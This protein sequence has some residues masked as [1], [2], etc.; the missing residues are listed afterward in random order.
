MSLLEDNTAYEDWLRRHCD[1]VEAD[2]KAKH[3][4]MRKNAFQF[5]RAT[6]FRWSRT[7]EALLPDLAE[8]PAVL[9][10]GDAHRGNFGTWRD[11]EGRLIWGIN[12][13]DDA[14]LMPYPL[15]LVRLC[16]SVR[17][18]EDEKVRPREAAAAILA[19]YRRGLD[20]P[21]PAFLD[22]EEAWLRPF[23]AATN[24]ERYKFWQEVEGA[25]AVPLD[26]PDKEIRHGFAK[27]FP[28]D[29]AISKIATW[30]KGGG[31]LGRPRYVAT[32]M[33]R[34][35]YIVREA[36]AL[37]P[38]SWDWAHGRKSARSHFL[39]LADGA[40]RAPD[41]FLITHKHFVFRRVS[42][43]A[44]KLDLDQGV[45]PELEALFLRAMGFELG[46][47]HA[48]DKHAA[49]IAPHLAGLPADWLH[50]AAK[51]AA[52]AVTADF[53]VWKKAMAQKAHA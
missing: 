17:L 44:R 43:D 30:I 48:A 26:Q 41:P 52:E 24:R 25:K 7:I 34:G 50:R 38:S 27:S 35:G 16:T 33:W 22:H 53:Q 8:A 9:A 39:D 18:S 14:A 21:R 28:Q 12:D 51:A 32:A 4:Y 47:I 46:S 19:G 23:M 11:A 40:N 2:L 3:D 49:A 37:V 10:V 29:A 20:A 15:D 6:C 5:L 13:F 1:V 45:P 31:S 42:P 36:K